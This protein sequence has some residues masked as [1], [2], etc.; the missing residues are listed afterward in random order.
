MLSVALAYSFATSQ[1]EKSTND[2]LSPGEAWY[3]A[4]GVGNAGSADELLFREL[5]NLFFR[6][7]VT[8]VAI[9]RNQR[10]RIRANPCLD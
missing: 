4:S 1:L 2:M 7:D 6:A 5:S 3:F 8:T 10:R 9:E